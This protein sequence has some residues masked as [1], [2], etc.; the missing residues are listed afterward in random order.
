V[1]GADQPMN[2]TSTA[3]PMTKKRASTKSL[4]RGNSTILIGAG[5]LN[6]VAQFNGPATLTSIAQAAHMSPSRTYRYL[7]GLCDS[8]LLEQNEPSGLYDLGPQILTLGLK[9]IGRLDPVRQAIAALPA[10]TNDTGLVSV[11]TVWGSHGPTAI[12]CEH[13]NLAA[14]IRIREG[15]TLSLFKTSAGKVFL[16]YLPEAE[17]RSALAEGVRGD[18]EGGPAPTAKGKHGPKVLAQDIEQIRNDVQKAGLARSQ[19]TQHPMYNSLSAPVFDRDGRIQLAISLI[20]VQG[21]FALDLDGAPATKLRAA[22]AEVSKRLGAN[23][24][25]PPA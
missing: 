1:T 5:L 12:R 2:A 9:A 19:G 18:E 22:A 11:I 14:P 8:G 24:D 13:G 7:R 15:I 23:T 17:I 4:T 20:G 6:V 25:G 10:L 16:A 21:T 3:K